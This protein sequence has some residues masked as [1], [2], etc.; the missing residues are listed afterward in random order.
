MTSLIAPRGPDA[1]APA[2]VLDTDAH[3]ARAERVIPHG[4]SAGGRPLFHEVVVRAR[5]AHLETARGRRYVDHLLAYGPIVLGHADPHVNAAVRRTIDTVDLNW[6]GPQAGEVELAER[7]VGLVPS[8]EKV[9]LLNTGTDALQHALHVARA[10]TGRQRILKFHGHYHGWAGELGTGANFDVE[11]GR[12]PAPDA[13]NSGGASPDAAAG[14]VV[15]DW[16]DADAVRSAFDA[17][18]RQI[19]AVFT[20]PYLHSYTNCPPAPGFLEL[21][22]DLTARSGALLVFDEVK[23]GFRHHLGGYQAIAGVT[24]DLTALGKALGNGYTIAALAGRADLMDLLG[25]VV[26][27]DGTYYANPYA[28]AAALATLDRLADGGIDRLWTLGRRLRDG[29]TAAIA[30]SGVPANVTGIGSGWIINWRAEPPT[31]FR[32]A[33]DADFDRGEAFR[34]AMLDA[35]VLLPPYVITDAR[36]CAAFTEDDVDATIDAARH[37]LAAVR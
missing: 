2:P 28:T 19:A 7:I 14:V 20:E 16:N 32:E 18:G 31:T 34:T 21:L 10:A 26:T 5:G 23:T 9:V 15:V 36:I 1:P 25:E 27:V 30:D 33:V 29:L 13:P 12:A 37:A 22:R 8:A 24:P 35:G 17:V 11:P 6:V 3:L 4:A